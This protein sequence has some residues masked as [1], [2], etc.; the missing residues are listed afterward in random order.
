MSS[1]ALGEHLAGQ[2][3][4][5]GD[6]LDLVAEELHAHDE[7][8]VRGLQLEGVATDAEAGARQGLVVALVLQV[9]QLAEDAV[10]P[11]SCR[12]L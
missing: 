6:A 8:V 10:A 4:E 11:V 5:L 2:R 1:L 12:R 9:D 3:V 7:V